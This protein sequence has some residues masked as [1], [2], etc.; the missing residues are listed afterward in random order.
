[1]TTIRIENCPTENV[2][3]KNCTCGGN[4]VFHLTPISLVY[5][6]CCSKCGKDTTIS[7]SP[8]DALKE[9]NEINGN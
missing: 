3:I 9:W 8:I 6:V 4:P 1:M 2:E 7:I 5:F